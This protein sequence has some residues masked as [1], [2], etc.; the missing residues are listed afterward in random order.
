MS[1]QFLAKYSSRIYIKMSSKQRL[2]VPVSFLSFYQWISAPKPILKVSRN[3]FM[4]FP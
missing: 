4:K 1:Q 3:L 2:T